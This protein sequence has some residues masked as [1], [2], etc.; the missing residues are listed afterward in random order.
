MK[1]YIIVG[2][3]SGDLHASNLIKE[4]KRLDNDAIIRGWGGDKMQQEGVEIVRHYRG[5]A[6]MGFSEVLKN[7]KTVYRNLQFCK[8]DIQLWKPDVVIMVDY[9]GFNLRI[10]PF[11][12]KLNC[13]LI[14]YISPQLWAW[15]SKRVNIIKATVDKMITV[16][17]FEKNFY[18]KFNYDVEYVGHPLLDE[19]NDL[20]LNNQ[21]IQQHKLENKKI[22]AVLPGSRKQEIK[23]KLPV[24]LSLAKYYPQYH[25]VVACAPGLEK[26]FYK[27]FLTADNIIYA[28]KSTYNILKNAH[29]ALV[30]SG[31][32]TL[33]TALFNVPQIVCYKGN[34]ISYYI[35]KRLVI[36]NYISL[37]NL[38]LD[39]EVIP[40]LIQFEFNEKNLKYHFNKLLSDNNYRFQIQDKYNLLRQKLGGGGASKKAAEIVFNEIKHSE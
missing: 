3:A 14:Y 29:T 28:S 2:E 12:K 17:P 21:F 15:N 19:L 6:F 27:Q 34:T 38:I 24:M 4:L 31:T 22:I 5:L 25:F 7:I 33:E 32:A 39:E 9:P 1:Y 18:K 13:K 30:T 11:V 36:V 10:A 16:L 20:S 26:E 40:E 23:I 8:E 35:A 37:V